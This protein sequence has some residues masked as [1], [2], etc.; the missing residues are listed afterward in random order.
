MVPIIISWGVL[1]R[2]I[3]KS[4]NWT[5]CYNIKYVRQSI[6]KE[7]LITLNKYG[8]THVISIKKFKGLMRTQ[9]PSTC[10]FLLRSHI[11][12]LLNS[13]LLTYTNLI[14]TIPSC[15]IKTLM[16]L[17]NIL[18]VLY[19]SRLSSYF[20]LSHQTQNILSAPWVHPF[21][22]SSLPHNSSGC[23]CRLLTMLPAYIFVWKT[24]NL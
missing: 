15:E 18:E 17:I 3:I 11:L 21:M 1:K 20:F 9:N 13:S 16:L 4:K 24:S 7:K 12:V 14:L 2:G 23:N 22:D 8:H 10:E 5:P 19:P 6:Y